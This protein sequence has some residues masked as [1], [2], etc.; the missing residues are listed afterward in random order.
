VSDRVH[1]RPVYEWRDPYCFR[2]RGRDFMLL[3]G[4]QREPRS[5]VEG[6][7]CVF[8]YEARDDGLESWEYRGVLLRHADRRLRSV[9]SP[10][11]FRLGDLWVLTLSPYGPVEWYTGAFDPDGDSGELFAVENTGHV[12]GLRYHYASTTVRGAPSKVI[13]LGWVG[14]FPEG[15]GW[16]GVLALPRQLALRDGR[17]FQSPAVD[18]SGLVR[19]S[20]DVLREEAACENVFRLRTS[21]RDPHEEITFIVKALDGRTVES[22]T[23]GS[24]FVSMGGRRIVFER[25][26]AT[27]SEAVVDRRMTEVF[28]DT[29]ECVTFVHELLPPR[30][31][32]KCEA[33][34]GAGTIA[35]LDDL[36]TA[37]RP[38]AP[39]AM[40]E[41]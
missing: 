29:G 7:P 11:L 21:W 35:E 33:T 37:T 32:V 16:N 5:G 14:G 2:H 31:R 12:D 27:V 19:D 23:A 1:G 38:E 20:R 40:E 9:E 10:C 34:P 22:L 6:S 13:L 25:P 28:T 3:G 26:G 41:P 30:V 36:R 8:L 17:L 24:G 4:N 15:L 39:N 18:L